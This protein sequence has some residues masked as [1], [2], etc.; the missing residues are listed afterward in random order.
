MA[1]GAALE[2]S[3][4]PEEASLLSDHSADI[5]RFKAAVAA[6]QRLLGPTA[7]GGPASPLSP[8]EPVTE[9]VTELRMG[10]YVP[11]VR[12]VAVPAAPK[13]PK[14]WSQEYMWGDGETSGSE[15]PFWWPRALFS[16]FVHRLSRRFEEDRSLWSWPLR[17]A[18]S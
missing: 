6:N 18:D 13:V 11:A 14:A 9:P 5:A 17:T 15:E 4:A 12:E 7:V 1:R 3:P 2:A 8:L 10:S 16:S